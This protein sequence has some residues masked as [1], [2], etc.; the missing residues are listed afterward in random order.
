[1]IPLRPE[2][3]ICPG[4]R[5]EVEVVQPDGGRALVVG[6]LD[7]VP[8]MA[9]GCAIPDR[10]VRRADQGATC[11]VGPGGPG[12]RNAAVARAERAPVP[13]PVGITV[14]TRIDRQN[15]TAE[16]PDATNARTESNGTLTLI[17]PAPDEYQVVGQIAKGCWVRW[18]WTNAYPD[19]QDLDG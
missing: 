19:A 1:V 3:R 4:D 8:K 10:G 7:A 9:G 12:S 2:Y 5:I 14:Y 11:S 13:Q 17:K 15:G 16:Y 6:K 18:V